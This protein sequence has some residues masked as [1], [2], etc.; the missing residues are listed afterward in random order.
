MKHFATQ[1]HQALNMRLEDM[2]I[3]SKERV[4]RQDILSEMVY[5]DYT[6]LI[7]RTSDKV[8]NIFNYISISYYYDTLAQMYGIT[9]KY[10]SRIINNT[11]KKCKS[12]RNEKRNK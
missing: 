9:P 11:I 7:K 3:T 10:V 2:K 5:N 6:L 4:K 12:K 8:P 1:Q